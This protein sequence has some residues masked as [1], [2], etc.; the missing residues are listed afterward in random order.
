[1][2]D[3]FPIF[4]L[5]DKFLKKVCPFIDG[6]VSSIDIIVFYWTFNLSD[7]NDP[8][9]ILL[10]TLQDAT[11]RGV[12]VR[13][14]VNN[15]R[16]GATLDKLGFDVRML[17]T[18][19]LMHPKVMIIDNLVCIVGSHNYTMSALSQNWEVSVI[20][21]L[22]GQNNDLVAFFSRLWGI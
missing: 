1:M 2:S 4:V 10:K 19:K 8:V 22:D 21:K 17:Y 13:V 18:S 16:V 14:L 5:G 15:E 11:S 9:S 7:L 6:A 20:N 3:T 12:R